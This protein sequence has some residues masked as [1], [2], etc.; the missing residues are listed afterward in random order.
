[1]TPQ[2]SAT[3]IE[4][5]VPRAEVLRY[6]TDLR[7]LT[8]GRASFTMEFSHYEGVPPVIGQKVI[9]EIQREKEEART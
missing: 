4:A 1:M 8:Q 7:S 2:H 6:S 3:I 5:D 9:E